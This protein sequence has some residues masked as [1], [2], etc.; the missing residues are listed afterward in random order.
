QSQQIQLEI[1]NHEGKDVNYSL[2]VVAGSTTVGSIDSIHVAKGDT[3]QRPVTI[4]IPPKLTAV[5][6]G[7]PL[8]LAFNLYRGS[9]SD[10]ASPYR[11]LRLF[12]NVDERTSVP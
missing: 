8:A 7:Q 12:I 5:E 2:D 9:S 4:Q 1:K 11:S 3:W 6:P 10:A